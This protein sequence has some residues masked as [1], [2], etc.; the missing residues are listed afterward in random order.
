MVCRP[1][2]LLEIARPERKPGR[3]TW[4]GGCHLDFKAT[5]MPGREGILPEEIQLLL[6]ESGTEARWP[7]GAA[8]PQGWTGEGAVSDL[9]ESRRSR[10]SQPLGCSGLARPALLPASSLAA[11]TRA[12]GADLGRAPAL[13][14][15][16]PTS[17]HK[18]VGFW[19]PAVQSRSYQGL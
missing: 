18:A 9:P 19:K 15:P 4:L 12:A 8:S 1:V 3:P 13:A 7:R 16:L 6:E 10:G 5:E 11:P 14:S 2:T 17:L